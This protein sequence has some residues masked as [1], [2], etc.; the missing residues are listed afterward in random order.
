MILTISKLV[1]TEFSFFFF[2]CDRIF[3]RCIE[4]KTIETDGCYKKKVVKR[5]SLLLLKIWRKK[6]MLII[7]N[8]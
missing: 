6:I 8:F 5:K 2:F 4:I 1:T 7:Y 3:K